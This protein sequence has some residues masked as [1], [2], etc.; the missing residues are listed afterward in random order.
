[1]KSFANRSSNRAI[2]SGVASMSLAVA[3]AAAL[4]SQAAAQN[5]SPADEGAK[6]DS[7]IVVT[8]TLVRGV[9]PTGTNVIGVTA[10]AVAATGAAT[11]AQ[12]LQSVPQMGAFNA[13]QFPTGFGN[14]VT[15]NRPNLR[16]LPGVNTA[17]GSSTLVLLDGHRIVGMGITSASP[18]PD[19]IPSSAIERL[20]VVPD[21]GSAIYGSDAVAGVLNFTTRKKFDGVQVGGKIGFAD[22]YT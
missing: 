11:T 20:E 21:G 13:L 4:P 16:N 17:G 6:D 15:I 1:M 9:A 2:R 5:Q 7:E 12:L 3:M 19:V 10:D 18:D 22:N 14:S 8:G